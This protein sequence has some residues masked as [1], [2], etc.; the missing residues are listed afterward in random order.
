MAAMWDVY[1]HPEY[2]ASI[3]KMYRLYHTTPSSLGVNVMESY[4]AILCAGHAV[5]SLW[6][7][8]AT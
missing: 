1:T 5:V 2:H 7:M 4:C 6:N 3:R 8:V